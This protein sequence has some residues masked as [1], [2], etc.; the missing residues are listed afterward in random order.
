MCKMSNRFK[1]TCKKSFACNRMLLRKKWWWRHGCT[2][3][4]SRNGKVLQKILGVH[5]KHSLSWSWS[6]YRAID[7]LLSEITNLFEL[8]SCESLWPNF[9]SLCSDVS[10]RYYKIKENVLSMW[11][12]VKRETEKAMMLLNG[13]EDL[14]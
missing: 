10:N 7:I 13:I 12:L 2:V 11:H 4:S 6:L 9:G 14:F 1:K 5:Y 3:V 8:F